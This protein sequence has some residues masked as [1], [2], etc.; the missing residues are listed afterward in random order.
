[1]LQKG[2]NYHLLLIWLE[3][4]IKE[5]CQAKPKSFD[6]RPGAFYCRLASFFWAGNANPYRTHSPHQGNKH[7]TR[8][9]DGFGNREW[10][11][12]RESRNT[13]I[14]LRKQAETACLEGHKSRLTWR[15][16]ARHIG[17]KRATG[18]RTKD[19]GRE[20]GRGLAGTVIQ[21]THKFCSFIPVA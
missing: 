2:D 8:R 15:C 1:M 12:K 18:R 13:L 6:C 5:K 4:V 19:Q 20:R 11:Q 3:G 17:T 14:V 9:R 7:G 16:K 21:L 10:G